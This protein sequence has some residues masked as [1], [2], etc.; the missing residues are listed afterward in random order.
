MWDDCAHILSQFA[1][2]HGGRNFEDGWHFSF[3]VE[4]YISCVRWFGWHNQ[5]RVIG[6][7]PV[8]HRR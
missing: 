2:G 7:Q 1:V 4:D 6:E 5:W 3:E 8:E